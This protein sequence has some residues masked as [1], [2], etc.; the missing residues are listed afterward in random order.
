MF[1]NVH[2]AIF[3]FFG[4]AGGQGGVQRMIFFWPE[5]YHFHT[6]Y[7]GLQK[8]RRAKFAKFELKKSPNSYNRFQLSAGSKKNKLSFF[9]L[10]DLT[11]AM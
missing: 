10:L 8:R 5:K 4:G 3:F 6:L 11:K 9:N 1:I 2:D 7:K